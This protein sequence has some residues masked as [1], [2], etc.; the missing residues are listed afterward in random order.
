M[1]LLTNSQ[2]FYYQFNLGMASGRGIVAAMAYRSVSYLSLMALLLCAACATAQPGAF[3]A[4]HGASI[5]VR[6]YLHLSDAEPACTTERNSE[7]RLRSTNA[8]DICTSTGW[9]PI[10][11]TGD[12]KAISQ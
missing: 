11:V 7:L 6:N 9:M 2:F 8:L 5:P 1:K 10:N 3:N 4:P 12:A